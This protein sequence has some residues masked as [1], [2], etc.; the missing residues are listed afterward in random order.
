MLVWWHPTPRYFPGASHGKL[1]PWPIR[2]MWRGTGTQRGHPEFK[3]PESLD[4]KAKDSSQ[5][6]L[7]K[8]L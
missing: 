4:P 2:G 8:S 6:S 7:D 3:C 5:W 1:Y